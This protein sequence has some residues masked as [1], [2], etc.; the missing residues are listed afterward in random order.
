LIIIENK[1]FKYKKMEQ[2]G[3]NSNPIIELVE[4]EMVS[5]RD[6]D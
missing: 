2:L 4:K 6:L 5:L 1:I 3:L